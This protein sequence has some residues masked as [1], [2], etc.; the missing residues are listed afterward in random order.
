[1]RHAACST[2]ALL[3]IAIT[4]TGVGQ[5]AWRTDGNQ[6]TAKE[7]ND[8]EPRIIDDGS[9]GAIIA[10]AAVCSHPD[11]HAIYANRIDPYGCLFWGSCGLKV[12][13]DEF[14]ANTPVDIASDGAGGAIV[15]WSDTRGG[16]GEIFAQRL[17]PDGCFH[18]TIGG[19]EVCWTNGTQNY[20][21]VA[22]DGAGG[23]VFVW[24]DDRNGNRDLYAQRLDADG[25]L[26]WDPAGVPVC[27]EASAQQ[28]H[29]I[30][31]DGAGGAYIAWRDVRDGNG[32]AAVYVQRIAADGSVAWALD[33]ILVKEDS[34]Y[35]QQLEP[36]MA[37]DAAG[38]A[39]VVWVDNQAAGLLAQRLDA[40]GDWLWGAGGA[41]VCTE[42][43]GQYAP[44]ICAD[45]YGGAAFS[46]YDSRNGGG[47][48]AQRL[49]AVGSKMW[50]AEGLAVCFAIASDSYTRIAGD[51]AGGAVITWRNPENYGDV[52]ARHVEAAGNPTGPE[53]G[54][55]LCVDD[56]GQYYPVVC[57]DGS[58]GGIVAWQDS[59][60]VAD[61]DSDIY[62]G[63]IFANGS[64]DVAS[65]PA[66]KRPRI[67]SY[68]N[69]F[70]PSTTIVYELAE[71]GSVHLAI[72]DI[73][74]RRLR[75]LLNGE[76]VRAGAHELAW[77][78]RDDTGARLGSGIYL[79]RLSTVASTTTGR[80]V[81]L[82]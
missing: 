20:P 42:I 14:Q 51:G 30:V 31:S 81:L 19:T 18:W 74:G 39:I 17:G 4:F 44:Q 66:A 41:D 78:G 15:C 40:S 43:G 77:D 2:F 62:A 35:Y 10:W 59:R 3:L 76:H 45:G 23:G 33:G 54:T 1:M 49:S 11:P 72:H 46:W 55:V 60:N 79:C 8:F 69:P 52:Y 7:E 73:A 12:S 65:P 6:V 21:R 64:T 36:R 75:T 71:D 70:N 63:R 61:T 25:N 47:V 38:G 26:L 53:A 56:A 58:G 22:A 67:R 5:A 29:R 24:Y 57:C 16:N 80:L 37:S 9:G 27:T 32:D 68:P 34:G 50:T 48:Y 13:S 28:G 82:K